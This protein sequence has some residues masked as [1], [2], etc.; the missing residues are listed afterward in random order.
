MTQGRF[1]DASVFANDKDHEAEKLAIKQHYIRFE[2]PEGF[3][4]IPFVEECRALN[5]LDVSEPDN[6]DF[7]FDITMQLLTGKPVVII[8]DNGIKRVEMTKFQ[9]TNRYMNLRGV[10]FLNSYPILMNWLV[11]MV[12][13]LLGKKYPRSLDVIEAL[14]SGNSDAMK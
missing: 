10:D 2:F 3:A 5:V 12:A 14:K 6:F 11:E 13:G 9:V 4:V 7:M 8:W 1:L